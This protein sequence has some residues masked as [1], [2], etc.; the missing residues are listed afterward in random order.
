[1]LVQRLLHLLLCL[2]LALNGAGFAHAHAA[3]AAAPAVHDATAPAAPDEDAP[4]CHDVQGAAP[5]AAG[6]ADAVLSAMARTGGPLADVAPAPD[7]S[8]TLTNAPCCDD[9]AACL[10]ACTAALATLVPDAVVPGADR[11]HAA[12]PTVA[13]RPHAPPPAGPPVRPPIA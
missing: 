13:A 11:P 3:P 1:M 4:P 7:P 12:M 5:E 8:G 6:T 10:H 2:T 9:E